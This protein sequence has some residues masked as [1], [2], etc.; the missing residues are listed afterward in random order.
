M[1][2]FDVIFVADARFEGGTSTAIAL[3]MKLAARAGLRIGL[4]MVKGHLLGLPF[5]V[6][7]DIRAVLDSGR[8]ERLDPDARMSASL[9]V[10]HHP[11]IMENRP[12]RQIRLHSDSVVMV[13]HHPYYDRKGVV[14]FDL[15]RIVRNCFDAFGSDIQ[16]APVSTVVRASLPRILPQHASVTQSDWENLL[17]LDDWQPRPPRSV[18][19]PIVIGRHSRPD[20][21]KWPNSWQDA[22]LAYPRDAS[23]YRVRVLGAGDYLYELYGDI[24]ANWELLPFSWTGVG[25]FLRSL[26]FYVYYHSD[27]WSEAFGRTIL[28]AMAVGLIVILPGHFEELFGNAAVYAAPVQVERVIE[29]FINDP[30]AYVEQ[31]NR[32]RSHVQMRHGAEQFIGRLRSFG[33]SSTI[34]SDRPTPLDPL[35]DRNVL[36][37]S[38]NG[39]GV[40]HIAQQL[41][42]ARHLPPELKAH[43]ATMSYSIK[44]AIDEG[45]P[46]HFFTYH[47]H[48]EADVADWNRVLSE[49]LF[50]LICHL[51][52]VVF[53]YDATA[54]FDGV[55]RAIAT[56]PN[57]FSI[58]VRRAMW[59]EVHRPFL[60]LA[61]KFDAVIEPGELAEDFDTGPTSSYR[62]DVFLVPPVLHISPSARL[63][64]EVARKALDLD[65]AQTVV[66]IQLGSGANFD[67]SAVHRAVVAEL[68]GRPDIIVLDIRSPLDF[69][70]TQKVVDHPRLK[71]LSL[72]PCF[73][74][75]LAFDAAVSAAGYNAF[76]EQVLGAIPTIFV[77]NEAAEMDRQLARARWAT[78]TGRGLLLRRDFDISHCRALVDRLLDPVEQ[79]NIINSCRMIEWTNGADDIA[80]F[81]E[82]HARL[83]RT[84]WDVTKEG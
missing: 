37:M 40:G 53:S 44:T 58:W 77:P 25:A 59:R 14:Q 30:A 50:D 55:V 32:A 36:F 1:T 21:L 66:A 17:D 20:S 62:G 34:A 70:D 31:A 18:S 38:S 45:Y 8:A 23:K 76:H 81:I 73:R 9:T 7:P 35:P 56:H 12:T 48:I 22:I 82:D 13:L 15:P 52:P 57:M 46:A 83:V 78:L 10:I 84:D 51:K 43:F 79:A 6:H 16:L 74:Y 11:T 54:V 65:E 49:E 64:R 41:A 60:D 75:S 28:E 33:V 39:I 3:E 19:V 68:L 29:R 63:P 47:R 26:D 27:E 72:F 5:P 24:P 61:S 4:L 42:V 67:M 71:R 80:R 2:H 69:L